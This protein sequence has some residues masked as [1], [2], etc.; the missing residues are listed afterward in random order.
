VKPDFDPEVTVVCYGLGYEEEENLE[1]KVGRLIGGGTH[2]DMDFVATTRTP[3]VNGRPGIVK[4]EVKSLKRK[5][6]F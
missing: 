2:L 3:H 1:E 5:S 6:R 4:I